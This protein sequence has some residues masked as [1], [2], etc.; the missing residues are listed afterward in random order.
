LSWTAGDIPN[1]EGRVAV[2]TGA[3]GGLGLETTRELARRGAVVVMGVRDQEKAQRAAA[4]IRAEIPDARL[5]LR[6]LDLASL[7][8]VNAFA[9]RVIDEHP[10]IDLLINN[11]GVMAIPH[12]STDDGF[13]M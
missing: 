10:R 7:A 4:E 1:Q 11:A 12:S 13:E 5:V 6:E 8:S 2:V 3:N 9:E